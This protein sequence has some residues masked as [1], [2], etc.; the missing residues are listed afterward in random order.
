MQKYIITVAM[1]ISDAGNMTKQSM[2]GICA[3]F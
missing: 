1:L 3:S 2:T